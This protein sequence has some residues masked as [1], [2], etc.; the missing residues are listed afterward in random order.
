METR[1]R[2]IGERS[3]DKH[4]PIDCP[5]DV[6]GRDTFRRRV[7]RRSSIPFRQASC[8]VYSSL[9]DEVGKAGG[10]RREERCRAE[11][12][13]GRRRRD[14]RRGDS[15]E[16][17]SKVNDMT[18]CPH[19]GIRYDRAESKHIPGRPR[20]GRARVPCLVVPIQLF[21]PIY[22]MET[23]DRRGR[24]DHEPN[25]TGERSPK[26]SFAELNEVFINA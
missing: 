6:S 21:I 4:E 8:G 7:Q 5:Q 16:D 10:G 20:R 15:S 9:V 3:R 14:N 25:Y 13:E 19:C 17:R 18:E 1:K 2:C 26:K 11:S 12:V 23:Q 24:F 22:E